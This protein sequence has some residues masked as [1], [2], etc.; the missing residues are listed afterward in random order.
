[1]MMNKEQ[2]K[3]I[4][5]KLKVGD[6]IFISQQFWG[7]PIRKRVVKYLS[8]TFLVISNGERESTINYSEI[9]LNSLESEA[10]RIELEIDY[11]EK[12][13]KEYSDNIIKYIKFKEKTKILLNK[14]REE[15]EQLKKEQK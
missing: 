11:N 2:I 12:L 4:K 7:D 14:L 10:R 8:D 5:S 6:T 15:Y 9:N 1:M 3:E 13:Y